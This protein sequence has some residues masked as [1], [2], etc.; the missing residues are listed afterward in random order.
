MYVKQLKTR[1]PLFH[2][3]QDYSTVVHSSKASKFIFSFPKNVN[4]NVFKSSL[5]ESNPDRFGKIFLR[6][7][8]NFICHH[9]YFNVVKSYLKIDID[10][11]QI[12]QKY[13]KIKKL[14]KN[15]KKMR[16][17]ID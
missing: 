16:N 10:E 8:M 12:K 15:Y 14:V 3:V 6:L 5:V 2:M 9:V 11:N 1:S 13:Q 17:Q 7:N 4:L